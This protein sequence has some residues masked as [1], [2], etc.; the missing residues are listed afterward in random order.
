MIKSVNLISIILL[1]FVLFIGCR[2]QVKLYKFD[3]NKKISVFQL[4]DSSLI[5]VKNYLHNITGKTIQD[6][7]IIMYD[8]NNETCWNLGDQLRTDDEMKENTACFI[9]KTEEYLATRPGISFFEF[10]EPGENFNKI[11]K[12]NNSILTDKNL[13]LYHFFFKERCVCGNSILILPDG[14]YI[15]TRSDAHI[16]ALYY[17]SKQI[18]ELLKVR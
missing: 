16:N 3:D 12:Y 13:E 14:R 5:S 18:E 7:I 10:K 17:S 6:T 2:P 4:S 1:G 9:S 8:Y 15:F 11:K